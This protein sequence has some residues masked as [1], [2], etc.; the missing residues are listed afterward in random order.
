MKNK[1]FFL[2]TII[3]DFFYAY[4]TSILV[5]GTLFFYEFFNQNLLLTFLPIIATHALYA[6]LT[7]GITKLIGKIGTRTSILIA[8][9]FAALTSIPIYLFQSNMDGTYIIYWVILLV[10]AKSFFHT[11]IIYL[12]GKFSSHND[13][14]RQFALQRISII[15]VSV[16]TPIAGGFISEEF[17]FIGLMLFSIGLVLMAI[18]PLMM[19][20]NYKFEMKFKVSEM[21]SNKKIRK[22][23]ELLFFRI[24]S[25][26]G[27]RVWII[28]VFLYFSTSF[29]D[30]GL[31]IAFTSLVSIFLAHILGKV[32][33]Q[34][35]RK[36]SVKALFSLDAF[37]WIL[38]IFTSP[39][40]PIIFT[41]TFGK[42]TEQLKEQ[43]ATVFSFDYM[44]DSISEDFKDEIIVNHEMFINFSFAFYY[45]TIVLLITYLGFQPTFL[46]IALI[47][48]VYSVFRK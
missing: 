36:K 33:S 20:R 35:S 10:L 44:N 32:M 39:V 17:N 26:A 30:I 41:D 28:F 46:V 8:I 19:L 14:S 31:L 16:L 40:F 7:Y 12:Y 25:I 6:S 34:H 22:L 27:N 1:N 23:N 13:R 11:P 5:F 37:A 43:A 29:S 3:D 21:I 9:F 48:F 18:L 24:P 47:G 38:K 45:L 4:Q 42:F 2:I 15:T